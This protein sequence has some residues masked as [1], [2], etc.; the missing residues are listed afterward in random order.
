MLKQ[1][2]IQVSALCAGI[3]G[4]ALAPGIMPATGER[5]MKAVLCHPA[6]PTVLLLAVVI[7]LSSGCQLN[8]A[9]PTAIPRKSPSLGKR[10]PFRFI[11][12]TQPI[13]RHPPTAAGSTR[14]WRL[15]LTRRRPA[16]DLAVYDLNLWSLRDALIAAHQRGVTVRM[17]TESD[18]LD[19]P[20]M[21]AAARGR[22]RSAGRPPGRPDAQQIRDHRPLG[23]VE[24]FDQLDHQRRLPQ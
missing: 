8:G 24:R 17:V 3:M 16:V 9:A 11:S 5:M 10:K 12:P 21:Q 6:K 7:L 13:R 20:E 15:P 18:N 14:C 1:V 2:N 19:E 23:S 4:A 22:H